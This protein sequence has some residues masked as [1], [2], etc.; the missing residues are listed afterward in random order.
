[1]IQYR[2]PL[3]PLSF[4]RSVYD[5]S[6]VARLLWLRRG[7]REGWAKPDLARRLRISH[8]ALEA[9]LGVLAGALAGC[10]WR[11][12]VWAAADEAAGE[13]TRITLTSPDCPRPPPRKLA[14]LRE[15][16]PELISLD[17]LEDEENALF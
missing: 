9:R 2:A 11:I 1:M 14:V 8:D 10:P 6:A 17:E 12:E 15:D 5:G 4:P 13:V 16:G 7:T 3:N